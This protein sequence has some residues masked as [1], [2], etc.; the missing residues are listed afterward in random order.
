MNPPDDTLEVPLAAAPI[1]SSSE[2]PVSTISCPA[3]PRSSSIRIRMPS[4][5]AHSAMRAPRG[6]CCPAPE[7]SGFPASRILSKKRGNG[8]VLLWGWKGTCEAALAASHGSNTRGARTMTL[9]H[10]AAD[11]RRAAGA[12]PG[13][14]KRVATRRLR[15]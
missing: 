4:S 14:M 12:P 5:D 15:V 10:L 1:R 11:Q 6:G 3:T 7:A 9:S 8:A 13:S 2:L